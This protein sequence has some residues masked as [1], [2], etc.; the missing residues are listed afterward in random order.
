MVTYKDVP[1]FEGYRVGD[2]GSVWS[3][4]CRGKVTDK[5]VQLKI[6]KF[7]NDYCRVHLYT[8][9]ISK[10]FRV[11]RLIKEVFDGPP[12]GNMDVAHND[13][14]K[15]NN[16]LSNLRYATRKENNMDKIIH[17]TSPRGNK[18][19]FA[20]LSE[21]D[22]IQIRKMHKAGARQIKL[23]KIFGVNHQHISDI[24]NR[25]RWAWLT[26]ESQG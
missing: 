8:N 1:G 11:H 14:D 12:E 9:K 6:S 18:C 25:K 17:G 15:N 22:V 13:G 21:D 24:V 19:K 3:C 20:K 7:K 2:D 16:H 26:E 4:R 23:S 5:W 10:C